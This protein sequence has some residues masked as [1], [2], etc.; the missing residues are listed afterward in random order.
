EGLET[1]LLKEEFFVTCSKELE[2][3]LKEKGK[4]DLTEI[5]RSAECYL[6]AHAEDVNSNRPQQ[7]ARSPHA[8]DTPTPVVKDATE[9][10]HADDK[11]K[12]GR[13]ICGSTQHKMKDCTKSK[14]ADSKPPSVTCF[15]CHQLCHKSFQCDKKKKN[16]FHKAGAMNLTVT[17]ETET[18]VKEI[19]EE[20]ESGRPTTECQVHLPRVHACGRTDHGDVMLSC[21]CRLP[22]V[23]S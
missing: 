7:K 2:T 12:G 22:F 9:V 8:K 23:A 5:A 14:T 19:A 18:V 15:T 20:R 13:Y 6:E 16:W 1:M 3:F 4:M 17:D 11:K 21:G 10:T